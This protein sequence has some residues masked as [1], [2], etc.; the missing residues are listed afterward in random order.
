[1]SG[2]NVLLWSLSGVT[3]VIALFAVV[4]QA[5]LHQEMA[6]QVF[7][8]DDNGSATLADGIRRVIIGPELPDGGVETIPTGS[9]FIG[10]TMRFSS[11]H[12][13][14][15]DQEGNLVLYAEPTPGFRTRLATF[16]PEGAVALGEVPPQD[17][18]EG[19]VYVTGRAVTSA[20][21][22]WMMRAEANVTDTRGRVYATMG[23]VQSIENPT[24][25]GV[26][27]RTGDGSLTFS[28]GR[29]FVG[30]VSDAFRQNQ[31]EAKVLVGGDVMVE[32]QIQALQLPVV[33]I[34]PTDCHVNA[35]LMPRVIRYTGTGSMPQ[36]GNGDETN[37]TMTYFEKDATYTQD[38]ITNIFGTPPTS[39]SPVYPVE[40]TCDEIF[41]ILIGGIAASAQSDRI[42]TCFCPRSQF[43]GKRISR[44]EV[45]L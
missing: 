20:R 22:G 29:V 32:S 8:F 11:G 12:S 31:G 15:R 38:V 1:M 30:Y 25:T 16:T 17:N 19:G 24:Q 14:E 37:F 36:W 23:M 44:R 26:Q 21:D 39:T 41:D 9:V 42:Y 43:E 18:V 6:S 13:M 27:F 4:D 34:D 45:N 10:A 40:V 7:R 5:S 33:S 35:Y 2:W 28:D 3:F